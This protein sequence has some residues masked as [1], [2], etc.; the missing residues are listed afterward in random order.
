MDS[1][2]SPSSFS[3]AHRARLRSHIIVTWP[4]CHRSQLY[5]TIHG[6]SAVG[7]W[8]QSTAGVPPG[9]VHGSAAPGPKAIAFRFAM[10]TAVIAA[11]IE[12]PKPPTPAGVP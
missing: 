1:G 9:S 10:D 11:D 5:R 8:T 3:A 4:G 7:D 12:C 2:R 6:R